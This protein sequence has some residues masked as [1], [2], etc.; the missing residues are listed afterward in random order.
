[1]VTELNDPNEVFWGWIRAKLDH[2][3]EMME[4][5]ILHEITWGVPYGPTLAMVPKETPD[6]PYSHFLRYLKGDL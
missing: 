2:E 3:L 5:K 6:S 1:M 4:F